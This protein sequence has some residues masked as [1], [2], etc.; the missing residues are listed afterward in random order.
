MRLGDADF[1]NHLARRELRQPFML[2]RFSAGV[3]N[4]VR[5]RVRGDAGL[6]GGTSRRKS[7]LFV[8]YGMVQEIAS[9]S[10]VRLGNARTQKT[11]LTG[12]PEHVGGEEHVLLPFFHIGLDFPLEEA[13]RRG[14]KVIMAVREN[15]SPVTQ[16][17]DRLQ[18]C[19][20]CAPPSKN[21]VLAYHSSVSASLECCF[22]PILPL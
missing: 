12:F 15:L 17:F 1:R 6:H 19:H 5:R 7:V 3:I 4:G 13:A 10:T 18:Q 11:R 20:S 22:N 8:Q 2:L 21:L 16:P 14:P 9:A